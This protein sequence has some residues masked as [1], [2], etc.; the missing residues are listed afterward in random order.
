MPE[1]DFFVWFLVAAFVHAANCLDGQNRKAGISGRS[2]VNDL[3]GGAGSSFVM[4]EAKGEAFTLPARGIA[5][6]NG[7]RCTL[8]VPHRPRRAGLANASDQTAF[9]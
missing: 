8:M 3:A 9:E 4:A 1:R 6:E 2:G 7:A 5:Q